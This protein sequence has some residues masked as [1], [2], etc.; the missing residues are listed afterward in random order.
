MTNYLDRKNLIRKSQHGF[1][2]GKS[3]TSNIL[4]FME[5][6]TAV[7]DSG[8]TADIIFLD[9]AKAFDKVPRE[10]LLKKVQAHG[11]NGKLLEWI[12]KWL[13][14]RRQR[15]GL[16]GQFSDWMDVLSGVPQGSVLGPL[17]F[18]IFIN[19]LDMAV[20]VE[21]VILNKFADDTKLAKVIQSE[22]DAVELQGTLNRLMKWTE[23]WGMEFNVGKCEVMH[24]G[25][26][27][28]GYTYEMNG[29]PLATTEEVRDLGVIMSKSLKPTAQCAKAAQTARTVLGQIS[30]SFAYRDKKTF[31]QLYKMYVRPHLE[32]AIQVWSPWLQADI[33][34]L[35]KVQHKVVG[36]VAGMRARDYADKLIEL[37]MTTLQERRHQA[38][39]H[40]V[41]RVV[42]EKDNVRA[43][44]WFRPAAE[45]P[46]QTRNATG[47]L[48]LQ[49]NHGRLDIRRNFFSSRTTESWNA[50]PS[51]IKLARTIGSF[52]SAYKAHR[53][54]VV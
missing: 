2:R 48:N 44:T 16:N 47:P 3:C 21:G 32:F 23:V 29:Q 34:V 25:K 24:V 40:N 27:N 1:M 30:R 45:G 54:N 14:G 41:N 6:I 38:D 52:K 17:L 37:E 18:L 39:M 19:D 26:K 28:K 9:F 13:T 51:E 15:V 35:E 33:D 43:N 5:K 36:M 7:V 10:R 12:R 22:A 11:I 8:E 46:R 31:V 20:T 50:I 42:T 4:E 49:A 53:K